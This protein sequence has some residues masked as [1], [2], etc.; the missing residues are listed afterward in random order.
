LAFA[1]D[2]PTAATARDLIPVIRAQHDAAGFCGLGYTLLADG[3][4]EQLAAELRRHPARAVS[5]NF[6]GDFDSFERLMPRSRQFVPVSGIALDTRVRPPK[7]PVEIVFHV[8][9]RKLGVGFRI[10]GTDEAGFLDFAKTME[11]TLR[12][13]IE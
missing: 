11:C 3:R 10:S 4:D 2:V 1:L 5:A 6:L 13:L 12:E 8:S 7:Q 9:E